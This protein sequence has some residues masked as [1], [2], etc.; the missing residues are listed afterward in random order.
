MNHLSNSPQM[1][2]ERVI[3]LYTGLTCTYGLLRTLKRSNDPVTGAAITIASPA[4]WPFYVVQDFVDWR[5][6]AMRLHMSRSISD[7]Q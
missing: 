5:I 2:V 7:T 1:H 4:L 3:K 6:D